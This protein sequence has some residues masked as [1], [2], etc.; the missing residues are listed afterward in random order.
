[1][2]MPTDYSHD[3][4]TETQNS[5]VRVP[6]TV[7]PC[8]DSTHLVAGGVGLVR[9]DGARLRRC[10]SGRPTKP[11]TEPLAVVGVAIGD[12]DRRGRRFPARS[13]ATSAAPSALRSAWHTAAPC[14]TGPPAWG[15]PMP[16]AAPVATPRTPA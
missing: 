14:L 13:W 16:K 9:H 1:M 4:V 10:G 8:Q 6:N 11:G 3:C 15:E 5:S 2:Y 7:F 12:A